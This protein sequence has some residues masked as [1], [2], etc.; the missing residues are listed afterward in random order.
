MV[1]GRGGGLYMGEMYGNVFFKHKNI[2]VSFKFKHVF[3]NM[4]IVL[5][6]LS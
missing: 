2:I 4:Y 5:I 6:D 3:L 1:V